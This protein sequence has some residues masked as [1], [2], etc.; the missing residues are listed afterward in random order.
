MFDRDKLPAQLSNIGVV[1]EGGGLAQARARLAAGARQVLLAD[2]AL[3]DIS[4][5]RSAL[6]EFG[7]E[8]VGAWLPARRAA[9]S[10]TLDTRSNGDFKCMSPSNPQARWEVLTSDMHSTGTDVGRWVEQL[11]HAGVQTILIS[12]DMQD[13]RDLDLCAG[14]VECFGARLWFSSLTAVDVDFG[15]WVEF[16]QVSRLV[17]PAAAAGP[18]SDQLTARFASPRP[19]GEPVA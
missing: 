11:V 2:A 3:E 1:L 5:M 18:L 9:V 7:G 4:L 13:D 17:L 16:A 19:V 8:R 14:L 6:A 10:W 12:V 15:A